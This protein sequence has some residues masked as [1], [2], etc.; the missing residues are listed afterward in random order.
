MNKCSDAEHNYMVLDRIPVQTGMKYFLV[1]TKCLDM[2]SQVI[3]IE[4]AP[5]GGEQKN[6]SKVV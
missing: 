2:S 6:D 3:K 4:V 5:E 1:C